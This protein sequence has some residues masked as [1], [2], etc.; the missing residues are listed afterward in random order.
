MGG[1]T[2]CDL[3]WKSLA[4]FNIRVP[5]RLKHL[6]APMMH[7]LNFGRI[8]IWRIGVW[9]IVVAPVKVG[10]N[11]TPFEPKVSGSESDQSILP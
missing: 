6:H 10:Y 1:Y 9:P 8:A 7:H 4:L 3:C 5:L 2:A 11:V